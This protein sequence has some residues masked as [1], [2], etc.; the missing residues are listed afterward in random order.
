MP[1][2]KNSI[3]LL[4]VISLLGDFA[5]AFTYPVFPLYLQDLRLGVVFI[6]LADAVAEAAMGSLQLVS[7]WFSD[8][9]GNRRRF[10]QAGLGLTALA[11]V[12][13]GWVVQPALLFVARV[14][15]SLGEG[16]RSAPHYAYLANLQRQRAAP[17]TAGLKYGQVFGWNKAAEKLGVGLGMLAAI[18]L[19]G[20]VSVLYRELFLL[21]T[22]PLALAL[23]CTL[24]LRREP[25]TGRPVLSTLRWREIRSL[26][27]TAS[28]GLRRALRFGAVYALVRSSDVI[29]LLRARQLATNDTQ[30]LFTY[31][32]FQLVLVAMALLAGRLTD[33]LGPQKALAIGFG[34]FVLLYGSLM[35]P[36]P[37]GA[38][39]LVFVVH[40]IH[41]AFTV[42]VLRIWIVREAPP[43][44]HGTAL[45][46]YGLL[47]SVGI[48]PA[49]LLAG[50]LWV[51]LGESWA[52]GWS[53][54]GGL[55]LI[56]ALVLSMR[57]RRA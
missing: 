5:A 22:L 1:S 42:T 56:A 25:S 9:F 32:G 20:G 19:V 28:P 49:N 27:Q 41:V 14:G 43:S 44:Q 34:S 4:L 52:F 39:W 7:G 18:G 24:F 3:R 23:V 26:W 37:P 16:I 11:F 50:G 30:L 33:R 31:F 35:L 6:G 51:E 2:L 17:A 15:R 55:L 57:P 36:L 10:V 46:L 12:G 47:R 21:A 48:L 13:Y 53:A 29:L 38:L 54:V 8:R 45:G 40:G